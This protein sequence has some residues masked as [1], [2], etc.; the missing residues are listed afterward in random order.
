MT[1]DLKQHM[2][3]QGLLPSTQEKYEEI[4]A[5]AD[6]GDLIGWINRRVHPRTPIGTVLPLRAAV[7]HYLVAVLGYD[8]D[9]V[10]A[11]IPRARGRSAQMRHALDAEQLAL[12]HAAVEQLDVEPAKTI[13]FLLPSTGMRIGEITALRTEN[14]VERKGRSFL[15]FRGKRDKERVVPLTRA[16]EGCLQRYLAGHSPTSWL[17]PGKTVGPITPHAV[18][19]YT[20]LIAKKHPALSGLS[21]H[22]LRHSAATMWLRAGVD[23]RTLQELLGHSSISTTQRYLHPDM[24]DLQAALD[25]V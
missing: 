8:P 3:R 20:R 1:E 7:K 9:E 2:R 11:L 21:P 17:F 6:T 24:D 16:G 10:G 15:R 5:S 18:R 14:I 12:Y 13:L 25:K 23:L 19:K 22:V 4:L